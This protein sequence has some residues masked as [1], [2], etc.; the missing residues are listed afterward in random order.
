MKFTARLSRVTRLVAPPDVTAGG[1]TDLYEVK[2]F[3]S[4]RLDPVFVVVSALP[5]NVSVGEQ[6]PTAPRV[7]VAG[8]FLKVVR[9]R[10][11][12]VLTGLPAADRFA[13]LIVAPT[14][15]VSTPKSKPKNARN[16]PTS[17]KEQSKSP[18]THPAPAVP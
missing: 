5:A 18:A 9:Y 10:D 2:L 1:I 11:G 6:P 16:W 17:P 3:P 13:P 4:D 15:A 8:Y 14:F 7:V 12:D